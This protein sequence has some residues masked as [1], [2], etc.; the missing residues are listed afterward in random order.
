MPSDIRSRMIRSQISMVG[1]EKDIAQEH[2]KKKSKLES[3]PSIQDNSYVKTSWNIN[4]EKTQKPQR[5]V[6]LVFISTMFLQ[7]NVDSCKYFWKTQH[8]KMSVF[9]FVLLTKNFSHLTCFLHTFCRVKMSFS[10][11]MV[12]V[13]ECINMFC[14]AP[15]LLAGH[16][17]SMFCT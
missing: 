9:A 4:S 2:L 7:S 17:S 15:S 10:F 16:I 1:H 8:I 3:Q 6:L 12:I 5:S 11:F 14:N 13:C